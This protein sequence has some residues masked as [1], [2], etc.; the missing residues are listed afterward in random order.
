MAD[1]LP[2]R[3]REEPTRLQEVP[4]DD[5]DRVYEKV[6]ENRE[7]PAEAGCDG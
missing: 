4:D 5:P 1:E 6:F 7:P 3:N 2:T